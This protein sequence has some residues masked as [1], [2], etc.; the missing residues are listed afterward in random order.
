MPRERSEFEERVIQVDRISRVVKGGKRMR[1]RALVAIGDGKGK[2]GIGMGKALEVAS[3]VQKAVSVARKNL[4]TVPIVNETIPHE[5][6]V[7]FGSAKVLLKPA[8]LGTGIIAGGATRS[9][10][11][12]SGIKNI[13]S[14]TYGSSNRVNVAQTTFLAL[15]QL[16]EREAR[17]RELGFA[18]KTEKTEGKIKEKAQKK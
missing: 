17:R 7:T 6:Q 2:V 11:E 12:V 10:I 5:Q 1:F 13:L 16:T 3:A 9:I 4:L 14:K 8:K 18:E 15:S